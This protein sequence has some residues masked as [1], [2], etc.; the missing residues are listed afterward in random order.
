MS[1]LTEFNPVHVKAELAR[2]DFKRFVQ[3]FWTCVEPSTPI[4]WNWHLDAFCDHLT[5]LHQIRN[6]L[7][8]VPPGTSKSLIFC[9]FFPCWRWLHAA[10]ERFL[11]ATY[12]I[13]LSERDSM[14][15]RQV[16]ESPKFQSYYG[17]LFKLSDEKNTKLHFLN[18]KSGYRHAITSGFGGTATGLKG[19]YNFLDDP[20]S[21]QDAESE[22]RRQTVIAWFADVFYNRLND[23]NKGC[24]VVI[25]QRV[26]RDDLSA[27]ILANYSDW[28]HLILPWDYRPTTY[29]TPIG[30]K[31]PR[32]E[33]G[34]PLWPERF[35]A[36]EIAN[37]RR[38][39][40]SFSAQWNQ[41]PRESAESVFKA[42]DFR[43][44][45]ET[46]DAYKLGDKTIGKDT[47]FTILSCDPA[48]S[49]S[50]SADYTA[51]AIADVG[52]AGQIILRQVYRER[53]GPTKLLPKLKYCYQK[54]KP[55]ITLVEDYGFG[56]MV[57][58]QGRG[59]GLPI[60]P[61]RTKRTMQDMQHNINVVR[62]LDLQIALEDGKV[63]LPEEA[64]WLPGFQQELLDF[65][66][67]K[68]DDQVDA[69]SYLAT[70]ARK[71]TRGKDREQ[72]IAV[73]TKT[74][75]QIMWQRIWGE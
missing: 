9:V 14:K 47:T 22:Q 16:I 18:D 44:Y 75:E 69:V 28:T 40:Y 70:E 5:N 1:S 64:P 12:S 60:R 35:P 65:P 26:H 8:N 23:F 32:T 38:R 67:G 20:H 49:E 46:E 59:E 66:D 43:Y 55:T 27:F 17:H 54:Y 36:R 52:P 72:E 39:S 41:D 50:R 56:K 42:D 74:T 25:G 63:W 3:E 58:E 73:E 68:Y 37:L 6:L 34:Q 57:I 53:L 13:Q 71:R 21:A 19:D 30:W 45:T 33:A 15:C 24:R 62:S 51:I 11:M 10:S 2:R 29:V 31:D 48:M 61:I 4:L 7:I